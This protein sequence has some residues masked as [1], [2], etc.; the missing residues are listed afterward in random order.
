MTIFTGIIL[1][2]MLYWLIIF[3]VLPW[4]NKAPDDV[5]VGNATSAPANP[6]LKQKF[7]ATALI[8]AIVWGMVFA[9]IHFDVIDFYDIASQMSQEDIEK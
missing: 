5:T 4:G 3:T 9:L 8:A 1:Y 6:R 2:L 7:L